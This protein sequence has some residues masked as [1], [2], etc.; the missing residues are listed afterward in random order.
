MIFRTGDDMVD[1]D[2]E[3][4]SCS[5]TLHC[6]SVDGNVENIE[7]IEKEMQNG[8][9]EFLKDEMIDF[10]N[11]VYFEISDVEKVGGNDG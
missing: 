11:V 3:K 5:I 6:L 8:I 1:L 4:L 7:D 2:L 9:K 10:D